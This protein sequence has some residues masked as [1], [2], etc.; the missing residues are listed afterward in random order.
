MHTS[1]TA[2]ETKNGNGENG[3]THQQKKKKKEKN[4]RH[5]VTNHLTERQSERR[6]H[7]VTKAAPPT[8]PMATTT[9]TSSTAINRKTKSKEYKTKPNRQ[10]SGRD[11]RD[12]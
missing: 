2:T 11:E 3:R 10:K 9:A 5:L 7:M 1:V 8:H 4:D 12:I 6:F